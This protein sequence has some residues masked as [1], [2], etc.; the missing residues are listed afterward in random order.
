MKTLNVSIESQINSLIKHAN[1]RHYTIQRVEI[2]QSDNVVF[3]H[4]G[5]CSYITLCSIMD[6]DLSD[7]NLILN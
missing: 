1:R 6:M 5:N 2:R 7:I 3:V 4:I